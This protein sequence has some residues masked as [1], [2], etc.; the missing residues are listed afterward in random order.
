MRKTETLKKSKFCGFP[1]SEKQ[2]DIWI[3]EQATVEN[4]QILFKN[5]IKC[6]AKHDRY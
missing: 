2:M 1:T 4:K 6:L 3:M 5:H